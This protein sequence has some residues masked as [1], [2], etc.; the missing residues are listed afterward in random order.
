[1]ASLFE[2]VTPYEIF[3]DVIDE[4]GDIFDRASAR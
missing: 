2:Q 4:H 1:L 3:I